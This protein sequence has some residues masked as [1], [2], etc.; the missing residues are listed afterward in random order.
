[1]NSGAAEDPFHQTLY[2]SLV[3]AVGEGNCEGKFLGEFVGVF[4]PVR[5]Y[6][7][8]FSRPGISDASWRDLHFD[9][10]LADGAR[11]ASSH[12][13]TREPVNE[14]QK[15]IQRL[16]LSAEPWACRPE[17]CCDSSRV[18]CILISNTGKIPSGMYVGVL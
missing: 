7:V 17:N 18:D 8:P 4:A 11:G 6:Y 16:A 13:Y 14:E 15:I 3:G 5:T 2:R 12:H 1:M 9:M 10:L